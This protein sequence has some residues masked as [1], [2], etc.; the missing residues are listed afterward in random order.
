MVLSPN[1]VNLSNVLT[2]ARLVRP[3]HRSNCRADNRGANRSLGTVKHSYDNCRRV[4]N[5]VI[6]SDSLFGAVYH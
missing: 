2:K 3:A 5:T 6:N 1:A 4:G